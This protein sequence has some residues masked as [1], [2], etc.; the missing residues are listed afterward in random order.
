MSIQKK[1]GKKFFNKKR[2]PC[3]IQNRQEMSLNTVI[4]NTYRKC[5]SKQVCQKINVKIKIKHRHRSQEECSTIKQYGTYKFIL[6]TRTVR[7]ERKHRRI[8]H[9]RTCEARLQEIAKETS[10]R[11]SENKMKKAFQTVL[12][13][14]IRDSAS[15]I[16]VHGYG[17]KNTVSGFWVRDPRLASRIIFL[18]AL[19]QLFGLKINTVPGP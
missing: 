17:M 5:I 7:T 12:R 1:S 19:L 11:S 10:S 14:R 8:N 4:L 9:H 6:W 15:I 2:H 16:L 13:I 18:R 3:N